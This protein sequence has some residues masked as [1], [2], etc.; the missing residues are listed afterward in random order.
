MDHSQLE[1]FIHVAD[2]GSFNKA[3][4]DTYI[5]TTALIKRI[6]AL[7]NHMGVPLFDRTHRGLAL[8][9]AGVCFYEDAKKI[10]EYTAEAEARARNAMR[11]DGNAVVRIGITYGEAYHTLK[12]IISGVRTIHPDID[13]QLTP[14]INS[15]ENVRS[16]YKNFGQEF[17]VCLWMMDEVYLNLRH[18][19]G[20][21][22]YNF[23]ITCAVSYR[24]ELAK[25]DVLQIE[26]LYG[27]N[28]LL[29]HRNWNGCVDRLRDDLE[30]NHPQ[31][32]IVDFDFYEEP[33]YNRCANS[34]DVLMGIDFWAEAHPTLKFVP[35]EW[36]HTIPFGFLHSPHPTET[37]LRFLDAAETIVKQSSGK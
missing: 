19:S 1:T 11:Q 30:Q 33:V 32:K 29:M 25:K 23:P 20:R 37:V 12:T 4:E 21:A 16:Y 24:S 27:K 28:L 3:A 6:N 10:L 8:T 31:I 22:L 5:T 35:V 15:L 34:D 9:P 26:D 17:D 7:E 36:D 14:Y 18:C 2:V 13:I